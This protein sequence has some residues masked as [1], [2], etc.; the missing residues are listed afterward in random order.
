M[1]SNLIALNQEQWRGFTKLLTCSPQGAL[2]AVL[3][4]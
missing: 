2:K 3:V 1:R 4:R